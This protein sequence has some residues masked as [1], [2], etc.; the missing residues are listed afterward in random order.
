MLH[1]VCN[2]PLISA[3]QELKHVQPIWIKSCVSQFPLYFF[4]PSCE[5]KMVH[6]NLIAYVEVSIFYKKK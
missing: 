4:S 5:K 6:F 3:Q 1:I 2:Y